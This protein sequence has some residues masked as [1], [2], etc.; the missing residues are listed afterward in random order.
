MFKRK[1]IVIAVAI[2]LVAVFSL[3][4][5]VACNPSGDNSVKNITVYVGQKTFGITTTETNLHGVLVK[6][7]KEDKITAYE[8]DDSGYGAFITKIDDLVQ[9]NGNYYTVWHSLDKFE[10]KSVYNSANPE[11]NPSRSS[12]KTE[13]A[14]VFAV[15]TYKNTLLY[16]SG[17]GISSLPIVDG[18]VYAVLVG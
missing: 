18:A 1:S 14:G 17:V 6:L 13:E 11:W 12:A 5:L 3:A 7:Y 4:C 2:A 8:T 9:S 16:F 15:T 10:Y